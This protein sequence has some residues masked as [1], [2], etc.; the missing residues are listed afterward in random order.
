[1]ISNLLQKSI[2]FSENTL[3]EVFQS[4]NELQYAVTNYEDKDIIKKYE[5]S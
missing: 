4:R 1:M 3:Y 2:Q 5:N